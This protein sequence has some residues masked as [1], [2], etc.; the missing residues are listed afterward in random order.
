[1]WT[2]F[3]NKQL[4]KNEQRGSLALEQILFIG[5]IV[6]MSVGLFAF[7]NNMGNYFSSINPADISS[8]NPSSTTTP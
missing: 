3:F 1:M 6:A 2:L 7:Y 8:Y 4:N 5:A